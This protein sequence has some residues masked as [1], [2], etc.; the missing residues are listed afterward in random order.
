MAAWEN[1]LRTPPTRWRWCCDRSRRR[2]TARTRRRRRHRSGPLE[3]DG[4]WITDVVPDVE[5][6]A[7]DRL[8]VA[9]TDDS[10]AASDREFA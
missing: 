5:F 8:L 7:D 6:R 4:E 2:G 10:L 1:E 3:R 9:G